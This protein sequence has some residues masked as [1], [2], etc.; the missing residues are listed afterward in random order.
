MLTFFQNLFISS[1][2]FNIDFTY[3]IVIFVALKSTVFKTGLTATATGLLIDFISSGILGVFGFSR[4]LI[5]YIIKGLL[6]FIDLKKG[7]YV[8]L[9]I[10]VSLSLSNFIAGSIMFLILDYPLTL[11]FLL[12]QPVFT[13]LTGYLILKNSYLKEQLDVY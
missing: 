4:T 1:D 2:W 9:I 11:E 13:G 12:F 6:V 7:I 8:F 3:L 10:T 5:A